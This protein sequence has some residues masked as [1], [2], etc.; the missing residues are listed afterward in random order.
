MVLPALVTMHYTIFVLLIFSSIE[1]SLVVSQEVTAAIISSPT[2]LEPISSFKFNFVCNR[3]AATSTLKFELYT[4]DHVLFTKTYPCLSDSQVTHQ[5]DIKVPD[6]YVFNYDLYQR[7]MKFD[8]QCLAALSSLFTLLVL[9]SPYCMKISNFE[10][11]K[12][13]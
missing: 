10:C 2:V 5:L 1:D 7:K 9:K 13:S 4:S 11:L 12:C 8:A 6:S 3:K